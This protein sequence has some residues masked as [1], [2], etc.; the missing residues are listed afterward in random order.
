MIHHLLFILLLLVFL[1]FFLL[2]VIVIILLLLLQW[3][4]LFIGIIGLNVALPVASLYFDL[5]WLLRLGFLV[6]PLQ[7]F[8]KLFFYFFDNFNLMTSFNSHLLKLLFLNIYI[9]NNEYIS[10][11]RDRLFH[12]D[13]SSVNIL[14]CSF[15][16]EIIIKFFVL[17]IFLCPFWP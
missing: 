4:Q 15:T 16:R 1:L 12:A 7:H 5:R 2:L 9:Y 3:L 14:R 17:L 10:M 11:I 8:L 13:S 6:L